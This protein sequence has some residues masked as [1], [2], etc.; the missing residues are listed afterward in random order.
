[1]GRLRFLDGLRGWGAVFVV[2]YHVFVEVLPVNEGSASFLKHLVI[3]NGP[4]AVLVFFLVSGF[5][6]SVRYLADG[7]LRKW[8]MMASGRYFRLAIPILGAC[9]LVHLAMMAGWFPA[10]DQ[11]LP[12]FRGMLNFDPMWAHLFRFSLWDVFFDY[13][14][15]GTYIGPLWTMSIEL[16]GSLLVLIAIVVL[17]PA[18]YRPL[19]LLSLGGVIALALL[20]TNLSLIA[21][22]PA[23]AA[24]ADGFNRGWFD[25]I[26]NR[27]ALCLIAVGCGIAA[28]TPHSPAAAV[29][30]AAGALVVGTIA[31][32]AVRRFLENGCSARLGDLSFPLYLAHG[33]IIWIIGEPLTRNFGTSVADRFAIDLLAIAASIILAIALMVVNRGAILV[34]RWVGNNVA[35]M[36]FPLSLSRDR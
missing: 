27:I 29:G 23:G 12:Q 28:V 25:L 13:R 10:P 19:L 14:M 34:S 36:L 17:R 16:I 22:F 32:P 30:T 4:M 5:A 33:P 6:L 18:R 11:R 15:D 2:L 1:M 8:T 35:I 24:M 21:L 9:L 20:P 3:F 7:D 31:S 26:P